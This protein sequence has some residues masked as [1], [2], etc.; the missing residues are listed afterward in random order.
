MVME[1]TIRT[2]DLLT[3]TEAAEILGVSRPTVYNLIKKQRLHIVAFGRNRYLMR[4]EVEVTK[5]KLK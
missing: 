4:A 5:L 3:F 1:L 2:P